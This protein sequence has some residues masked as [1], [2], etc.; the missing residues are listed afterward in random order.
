M[1]IAHAQD[2]R[3]LMLSIIFRELGNNNSAKTRASSSIVGGET[4]SLLTEIFNL[5]YAHKERPERWFRSA[6]DDGV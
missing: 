6:D 4:P 1:T 5:N 3:W 2:S